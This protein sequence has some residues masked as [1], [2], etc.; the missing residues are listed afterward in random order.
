MPAKPKKEEEFNN[1]VPAFIEAQ[2]LLG[3]EAATSQL[4]PGFDQKAL[5]TVGINWYNIRSWGTAV[6]DFNNDGIDDILSGDTAGFVHL[7]TGDGDGNFNDPVDPIR[8]PFHDAYAITSGDFNNDGNQDFILSCTAPYPTAPPYIIEDGDVYLYLGKGDG[9]FDFSEQIYIFNAG[10]FVGDAGTDVLSLASADVDKDGDLDVIAGDITT[11]ENGTADVILFRNQLADSGNMGWTQE[12][13]ISAPYVYPPAPESPPYYPP[14]YYLHAYGLAFGD[15]DGDGDPDLLVTDRAAYLYVY[16]NDGS[17]NFEPVRYGYLGTRPFAYDRVRISFL[18]GAGIAT[19]DF[20]GDGLIDFA[21]SSSAGTGDPGQV[22]VWLNEGLD[23]SGHPTFLSI[24]TVGGA[25]TQARG[26]ATGQLNPNTDDYPDIVFGNYEG[27]LYGLI[28]DRTDTDQDGIVDRF[29]N[30]PAHYNPADMR[31]DGV[32]AVQVDLDGDGLGDPCD[33]DVDGDDILDVEDNCRWTANPVQGDADGDARGDL[34]DPR[35]D[36]PGSP[37][38]ESYEWQQAKRIAWGRRPVI[39]LRSDELSLG[40]RRDI[41]IAL[42]TESLSRGIPFTLAVTAMNKDFFAGTPSADFLNLISPDPDFEISQ[43]GTYHVC[44][45]LGGS[46]S[47]FDCGMD[48]SRSYSLMQVGKDSLLQSVDFNLASH[49]L[50]GFIAPGDGFNDAALEAIAAH[51]YRYM[52]SSYYKEPPEHA[53][54]IDERGLVHVPW[55][56]SACGNGRPYWLYCPTTSPDAHTGVDCADESVCRPTEDGLDYSPWHKYAANSMKERCRYDIETRYGVCSVIF[57]LGAYDNG[58]G[59]LDERA[60]SGYR[61]LLN[62]LEDLAQETNAVFMT[63]GEFTAA[64]LIDDEVAP[65]VNISSP[66]ATIY[67]YDEALTV[68]F[69]VTDDLSEVFSVQAVLNGMAVESG[70]V[71]DLAELG[72][73]THTLVIQAEDTAGNTTESSVTFVVGTAL[74][75]L[76]EMLQ[77][78]AQSGAIDVKGISKSLTELLEKAEKAI[79]KDSVEAAHRI[80]D[81]FILEILYQREN[82]ITQEAAD[83]LIA[84][85]I[86]VQEQL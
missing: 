50:D 1:F 34:C 31:L 85:A 29:D 56:Q 17:G 33:N 32:T 68:Q 2:R 52:A 47:E 36:R 49:A 40:Y 21:V 66:T 10:Y 86:A 42:V 76:K 37:G 41:A 7:F 20:N 69:D 24:G 48:E 27:A 5:G 35:D 60:F 73:G 11:S 83:Q 46:G 22:S 12:T 51:G 81:A 71:I 18:E 77:L 74:T 64:N 38:A 9:T 57:E 80:L 72:V 30:C 13:I 39:I 45:Y 28:A 3:S 43:H 58:S 19:A 84:E 67:M 14:L 75:D 65:V 63:I 78:F 44:S 53:F 4:R 82:N 54:W 6:A 61:Q 70:D 79:V 25:G 59:G 23:A 15:L 16:L 55:T 8:M 62:D 26:L